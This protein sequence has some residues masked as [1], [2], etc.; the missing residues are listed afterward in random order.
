MTVGVEF[1]CGAIVTILLAS[2]AL[3]DDAP[4]PRVARVK[5][6]LRS[7]DNVTDIV[8]QGDLL[9]V[10]GEQGPAYVVLTFE[11]RRGLVQKVNAVK[12]AEAVE[13]YDQLLKDKPQEGRIY[14]QRAAA[15]WARGDRQRAL[16]DFD[17]AIQ[18][19]YTQ[20]HAFT[21]RG[22]FQAAAGNID[23]A[24][25]DFGQAIAK[26]PK[27]EVPRI[28]RAALYLTQNKVDEALGDYDA[29]V[30]LNPKKAGNYQ[31]RA[32][33]HKLKGNRDAALADFQKAL[34][35]EP[36]N[37]AA[38]M[39]RGL[40][41]FATDQHEK[42]VADFSAVI[43]LSPQSATAYN[44]RGFNRQLMGDE[45]GALADYE[46]AL[47]LSP[48]YPLCLQN[49][50]WLLATSPTDKLRDGKRAI[51]AALKACEL[52][53]Y[54]DPG[55]LKALAAAYAEAGQ[56]AEA[57]GWQ[58]KAMKLLPAEEQAEEQKVLE[59]LL[60]KKPLRETYDKPAVATASGRSNGQSP[61]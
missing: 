26:D 17:K 7:G 24:L 39:G 8:E 36:K 30:S 14:N 23:A 21:S 15:W 47:Q 35:L 25:A 22:M 6:E 42:A 54:Q 3:A 19:G 51:Q 40:I 27:D 9:T 38:L 46:K 44:N 13:V 31:Q 53:K 58:E 50:A 32:V 5:M 2:A 33:A 49:K 16:A 48:D 12:L 37:P 4:E 60:D 55:D 34:E 20:S 29:A 28:N 41:Y 59:Q 56:F 61:D 43:E 18:L 45:A 11:G 57:I 52:N 10:V 1:C